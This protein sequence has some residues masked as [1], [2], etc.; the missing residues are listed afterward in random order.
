VE[1]VFKRM[2]QLLHLHQIRSTNRT[3]VEAT[4]RA[5]LIAWA[6]HEG[7]VVDLRTLL[8]TDASM[9][10]TPVS[11]WLLTG[12][13]LDT[14]RQHVQ[15]TWSEARLRVCLPRLRRL[16]VSGPRRRK[17]QESDVRAWLEQRASRHHGSQ[18]QVA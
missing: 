9:V 6:L 2:K 18:R 7:I 10:A 16:L 1:L 17:H 14:V 15:G 8:P 4:V 12:L 13:G 3:S 11:S 5:L